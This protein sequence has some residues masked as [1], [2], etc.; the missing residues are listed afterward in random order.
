MI[1]ERKI[2]LNGAEVSLRFDWGAV[3]DFCEAEGVTFSDFDKAVQSPKKLRLLIYH[4][5]CSAGEKIK[6]DDLRGMAFSQMSVVS[7]LIEEAMGEGKG[8]G[9]K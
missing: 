1:G 7:Q 2:Q 6:K 4:M 3:E 9:E 8:A 5:A